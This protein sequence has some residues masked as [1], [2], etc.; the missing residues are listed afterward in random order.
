MEAGCIVRAPG[1]GDMSAHWVMVRKGKR[2]LRPGG[3]ALTTRMLDALDLGPSAAVV[4]FAPGMGVTAK[5]AIRR[6]PASY[7]AVERDPGAAANLRRILAASAMTTSVVLADAAVTGLRGGSA[8]VVYCEA[9]L[10]MQSIERKREIVR[11]ARRLL[12]KTG[13]FGIHELCLVPEG[14]DETKRR[15]VWNTLALAHRGTEPL[16]IGEWRG[17]LEAEGFLIRTQVTVPMRILEPTGLIRDEGLF[18]SLRFFWNVARDR[19]ARRRIC[20]MRAAFQT[21]KPHVRALMLVGE[22]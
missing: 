14:V 6:R 11:E 16:T 20:D 21:C 9:M 4:E 2:V 5:L 13:R 18:G 22:V 10:T 19:D 12:G 1:A 7:T 17:L 3:F 15:N 8:A